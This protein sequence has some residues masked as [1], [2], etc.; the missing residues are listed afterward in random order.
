MRKPLARLALL[1]SLLPALAEARVSALDDSH[2]YVTLDAPARRIVAL[3]PFLAD[4]LRAAGAGEW[5]VAGADG[6]SGEAAGGIGRYYDLDVRAI[7]ALDPDLVLAWPGG[8]PPSQLATLE[9]LGLTL[10]IA[11]PRSLLDP[12]IGMERLGR[13]AGTEAVARQAAARYRGRLAALRERYAQARP[14]RVFY[15][16]WG[17]PLMTGGGGHVLSEA[18]AVCGGRNVFADHPART[19]QVT[20]AAVAE[21]DPEAIL[22]AA[23]GA[24]ALRGWQAWPELA[25]VRHGNLIS[26]PEAVPGL[27]GPGALDEVG[28]LCGLLDAARARLSD[29]AA[30]APAQ[31]RPQA[32]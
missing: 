12:A 31:A 5:L 21:R 30:D 11:H 4:T 19:P 23:P 28:A 3:A 16:F 6:G 10:Y 9:S 7:A 2:R 8:N 22:V 18:L 24:D 17:Q 27:K 14:L 20:A 26:L 15:A 29:P 25:A 13:L 32:R 1:A